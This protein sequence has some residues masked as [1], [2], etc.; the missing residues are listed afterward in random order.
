MTTRYRIEIE[1]SLDDN[2]RA[3]VINS[4]RLIYAAHGG[5]HTIEGNK[6]AIISAD[7]FLTTRRT[8]FLSSLNLHFGPCCR[9]SSPM[10][11]VVE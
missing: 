11:F 10:R 8:P 7:S 4:A 1:V 2:M 6:R 5:A 3:K 9:T